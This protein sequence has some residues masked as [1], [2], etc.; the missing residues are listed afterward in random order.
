M[1]A[2]QLPRPDP[3]ATRAPRVDGGVRLVIRASD[4]GSGVAELAERGGYRARITAEGDWCEAFILNPAGGLVGGD[5]VRLDIHA[6]VG[7]RLVVSTA[8][9]ERIYRSDGANA[10]LECRLVAD[11]GSTLEWLP[12]QTIA[13]DGGRYRRY[14]DVNAANDARVTVLE[15]IALGRAACGETLTDIELTDHWRIHRGGR[16]V[17]A[18]SLRIRGDASRRFAHPATGGGA[19]VTAT[20]VHVAPDAEADLDRVREYLGSDRASGASAVDGALIVRWLAAEPMQLVTRLQ[21][22]LVR[23]RGRPAPRGW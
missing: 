18:D 12:Q 9:A 3:V 4:R 21:E 19:R 17:L 23:F 10:R 13:Y 14:L 2:S 15:V 1:A 7:A 20:L 22:F 8:A 5:R 16:L 6:R 11:A